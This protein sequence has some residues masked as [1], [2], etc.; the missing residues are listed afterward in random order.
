MI[1]WTQKYDAITYGTYGCIIYKTDEYS[2]WLKVSSYGVSNLTKIEISNTSNC[3]LVGGT[4]PSITFMKDV[5]NIVVS[6]TTK[7]S[8]DGSKI[9]Y[10][11]ISNLEL[12]GN[13]IIYTLG[14]INNLDLDW[15]SN[16]VS[17]LLDQT[18]SKVKS[19]YN[20]SDGIKKELLICKCTTFWT[21]TFH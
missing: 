20:T 13:N 11:Y 18:D 17:S 6:W 14:N 19:F 4:N 7:N 3:N 8:S 12:I 10:R 16:S 9:V 15:N 2:K 5:S 1:V 21:K